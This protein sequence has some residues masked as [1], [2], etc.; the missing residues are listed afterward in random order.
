MANFLQQQ[1]EMHRLRPQHCTMRFA[2]VDLP[3]LKASLAKLALHYPNSPPFAT[4]LSLFTAYRVITPT[5][6]RMNPSAA[7]SP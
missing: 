3:L 1:F 2:A 7:A 4:L 6:I 5:T